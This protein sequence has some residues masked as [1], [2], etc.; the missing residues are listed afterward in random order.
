MIDGEAAA[1]QAAEQLS[2][3]NVD[4]VFCHAATK[5]SPAPAKAT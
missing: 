1:R 5:A 3:A 2:A 4:L